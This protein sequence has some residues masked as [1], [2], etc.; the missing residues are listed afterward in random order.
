MTNSHS[1][2]WSQV[3]WACLELFGKL[4]VAPSPTRNG[5]FFF[6]F[7]NLWNSSRSWLRQRWI[8][9]YKILFLWRFSTICKWWEALWLGWILLSLDQAQFFFCAQWILRIFQRYTKG[10]FEGLILAHNV[11]IFQRI[12]LDHLHDSSLHFTTIL[13]T[14]PFKQS[15]RIYET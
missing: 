6:F 9:E 3:N 2:R 1:K 11:C 14:E 15:C 12:F 13:S 10:T 8:Y 7:C 4:S 5:T